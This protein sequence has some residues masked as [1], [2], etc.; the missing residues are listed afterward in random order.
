MEDLSIST[1]YTRYHD[2]CMLHQY[3]DIRALSRTGQSLW[4]LSPS[5]TAVALASPFYTRCCSS[6]L[7][8]PA[9]PK[10]SSL[11]TPTPGWEEPSATSY[12]AIRTSTPSP[13]FTLTRIKISWLLGC[14]CTIIYAV[15]VLTFTRTSSS[16]IVC[17]RN[18][19]G[20]RSVKRCCRNNTAGRPVH[21]CGDAQQGLKQGIY[22]SRREMSS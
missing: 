14:A 16:F 13:V 3:G 11:I 18:A 10:S 5:T 8:Y 6:S 2:K 17:S 4:I 15:G 7:I 9:L 1:D 20:V 12:S 19:P 22:S 21:I